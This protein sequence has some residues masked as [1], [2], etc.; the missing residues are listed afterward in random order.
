M[1]KGTSGKIRFFF[2][3][4]DGDDATLQEALRSM[5]M[6]A[7]KAF[8]PKIVKQIMPTSDMNGAG[9]LEHTEEVDD[10]EEAP[11]LEFATATPAAKSKPKRKTPTMTLVKD[12]VLRPDGKQSLKEFYGEKDPQSQNEKLAVF[13]Y[14]LRLELE[15]EGVTPNH[16]YTCYDEVGVRSP[17]DLPAA[18][19]NTA[20]KKGWIDSSKSEAIDIAERGKDV[21]KHGF[22]RNAK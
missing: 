12:L 15:L 18:I 16:I 13:V 5:A 8:Q 4:V 20:H 2:G 6:I 10:T 21:V 11:E 22:P 3:E 9:L 17:V 7:G 1:A 14:Y 19:R